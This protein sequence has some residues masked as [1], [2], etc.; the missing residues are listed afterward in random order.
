MPNCI[1]SLKM[2][3]FFLYSTFSIIMCFNIHATDF[4]TKEEADEEKN[5]EE[6]KAKNA[7]ENAAALARSKANEAKRLKEMEIRDTMR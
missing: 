2:K 4:G 6:E 7:E 1:L 5:L 3:K